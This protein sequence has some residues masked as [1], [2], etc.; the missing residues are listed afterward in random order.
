MPIYK[1]VIVFTLDFNYPESALDLVKEYYQIK[2]VP[3]IIV[4]DKVLQGKL[5]TANEI[6][7]NLKENVLG[8]G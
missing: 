2:E 4:N 8:K 3:A 6:L 7:L 1:T 5:F